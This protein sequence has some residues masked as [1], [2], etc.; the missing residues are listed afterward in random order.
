[1]GSINPTDGGAFN[2]GG[3]G[4]TVG[5]FFTDS[6]IGVAVGVKNATGWDSDFDT[7]DPSYYAAVTKILPNNYAPVI[8]NIGVGN[9][10]YADINET[11]DRTGE[12]DVFGSVAVYVLPQVSLIADYT[13]GATSIGASLVPFAKLPLTLNV[14]VWDVLDNINGADTAVTGSLTYA[15]V[16]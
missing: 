5:R 14:G 13:A 8:V 6:L 1:M 9:N 10:G 15:F 7:P 2:R 12:I 3:V 11:V 16:F 4:L